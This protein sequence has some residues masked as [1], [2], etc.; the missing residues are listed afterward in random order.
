[1]NAERLLAHYETIA[2]APDAVARL[3]HFILDLAVRGKLVPQDV[4]DEP[5]SE[6]LKR[7][8]KEKARLA[9]AGEIRTPKAL[10]ALAEIPF[11]IPSNWRWSQLAEIGI[12]NPRNDAPD[13]LEASFVPMPLIAAEYGVANEHEAR[14]WGEIK[15][16]YTHFA[17]GDVGLAKIT[18]CFEN[19]KSAVFRNLTGGI[20]AGTTEL[21]VVRPLFIDQDYILLF[22]KSP[23]F[24]ETGIPKMTGTAGQKRVP[25]E[26]FAHSPFPLPPLAEQL[27]IVAK[28]DA[29]MALCDQLEAARAVREAV[30]DRLAAASLARLNA[31]DPKTFNADARFALDALPALTTRPDQIKAL[32]QTILN[33]A[34]RG[35]LVPQ[36]SNDEPASELLKR[37]EKAKAERKK[38]TGD[39]RIKIAPNPTPDDLEMPLPSGWGVQSFENLF[40]FIDYRGNTPPK[41]EEGIPLITAKNIRMGY[42]N[43]E[44]REYIST[45][46]FDGWMTRGFPK[47]GD[48]F[49]TTEA[50]LANIC[51]N[52]IEEPFALAQRAICFQPYAQIDTKFLM[53]AVMSD[54]MQSLIDKHATGMTAKGIKAANLKPLPIP[55]PPLAEQQRIVAKVDALMALCDHLEASL[56]ATAAT[57]RRLLDALLAE[58]LVPTD[59]RLSGISHRQAVA[60]ADD[61]SETVIFA[62][63]SAYILSLAY[64]RHRV[65][66][67]ERTF[68]RVKAQKVL[69][70][71]EAEA[72]FDLGRAPIRDAAGPNDFQHM[73][74]VEQWA[75]KHE[76]FV[77]ET[78]GAGYLLRRLSDFDKSLTTVHGPDPSVRAIATRLIDLFVPMDTRQAEVFATVYAAWN[79]LLIEGKAPT[80]TEIVCAARDNWHPDKLKLPASDF[81]AALAKLRLEGI[82]PKGKG[83]F[84]HGPRQK[85]LFD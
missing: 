2:D 17:E 15:K 85:S 57:R 39:A 20:G 10:P 83:K 35:K 29:L 48:L 7:I 32:R 75:R 27:R 36:D 23:H 3:R 52:D 58:A 76:R 55:I 24:I 80:D 74:A 54:V 31:P 22:L 28:V 1:M 69:H 33:L 34:V 70:L 9:K 49:F 66:R 68:G 82:I 59:A 18:P 26:Y 56:T 13:K 37:I 40:L 71:V 41:T 81:L 16:G 73:L 64:E 61:D 60:S 46:T 63:R 67:R 44:P 53:F 47:V 21:H 6:L 42:L 62:E 79:N 19:G 45:A 43:R 8:A 78:N 51:L 50:P 77:F 72:G 5:A 11:P 12:L 25:T 65:A 4:D 30:R 38:K 84:V 14:V